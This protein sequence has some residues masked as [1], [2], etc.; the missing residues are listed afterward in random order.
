MVSA[1]IER[2]GPVPAAAGIGL[3]GPHHSQFLTDAPSVAWLEAHSENF[4]AADSIASSALERIRANYPL[5][6]HGVGLSL[7]SAG[8]LHQE[9]LAKLGQLVERLDPGLVSEHLCWGAVGGY[10]LNDL[11]PVPYTEEALDHMVERIAQ[12][13]DFLGRQMEKIFVKVKE[14]LGVEV[15]DEA[16]QEGALRG[17]EINGALSELSGLI[18]SAD[19]QPV[20]ILAVELARRLTIGSSSR[21]ILVEGPQA[22]ALLNQEVKERIDKGIGVIEKGAPRVMIFLS[23]FSDPSIMRMIEDCGLS[24]PVTFMTE[25]TAKYRR[26]I[27]YISGKILAESEM[28]RGSFHGNYG[29]IVRASEVI[30]EA[31]VDGVI[32]NYLF[33]CRPIG[34]PAYMLKRFV[35]KE[36]GI[37]VL[38]LEFDLSDSRTYSAGALRTRVETFA[39]M[40]RARKAV[41]TV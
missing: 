34:Q 30:Q 37:P 20:S 25:V 12:A 28:A 16:R 6:L 19:P 21:R 33:N 14:I 32:W 15:T 18:K 4:F 39:E 10:H 2:P 41:A 13:Q 36:A 23:H 3:R 38:P 35:E 11:L 5:S 1:T 29:V 26:T 40:L 7:G 22:I 17:R 27:P 9:H 8:P 31:G 24:I